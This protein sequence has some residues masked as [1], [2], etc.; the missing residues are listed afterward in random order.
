MSSTLYRKTWA[1][2]DLDHLL[3]NFERAKRATRHGRIIPVVKADAYGHGAVPVMRHLYAKGV[4]LCAVSLIEEAL[5]LRERF[6]DLDI[7]LLGPVLADQLEVCSAH[8]LIVTVYDAEFLSAV[9]SS[10]LPLR[11]HL[12]VDTGMS[13]YGL[14]D[15]NEIGQAIEGLK[16]KAN[17]RLEGV[18]THFSTADVD[19]TYYR[20]QLD[21]FTTILPLIDAGIAIHVGNSAAIFRYE[22]DYDFSTHAR[23]GC[24]LYGLSAFPID[25]P[26][27]GVMRL[28]SRIAQI[29][30]V[31]KGSCV[32]YGAT[33]CPESE[34][35]IA[36]LPVGYADGFIR[37]NAGGDVEIHRKRYPLVG[38]IC[39]DA[40]FVRVDDTV[41]KG[42]IVTL[43]GGIVS[44]D[45]VAK[46][47][48]TINYEV[49][50][51]VSKRVPRIYRKGSDGP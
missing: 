45:E 36:I 35:R 25:P 17:V 8:D 33:Y 38:R 42:D 4:R 19:E 6:A 1:E 16:E 7:L 29:R 2:I 27:K 9:L 26:L 51:S 3:E 48:D 30:T 23:L 49:C 40:C 37:M 43:F 10:S 21:R 34:E 50:T 20:K 13:R 47:L 32:G 24:S 44:V 15:Q 41:R 14:V 28:K 46:R 39:M 18:Y 11:C 22:K 31:S 12:K 5:E